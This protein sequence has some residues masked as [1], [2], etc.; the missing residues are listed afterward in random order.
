MGLSA[1]TAALVHEALPAGAGLRDLGEHRLKDLQQPERVFQLTSP[2][3][4]GDFP[5]LRTLDARPHNL[6]LQLTS[7]VGRERELAG[8]RGHGDGH[9]VADHLEGDL[10]DHFRDD[11]IDLAGHN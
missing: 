3:L 6:P 10:V 4:P 11:R 9:I 7:F 5:A 2:D 8:L 1:V